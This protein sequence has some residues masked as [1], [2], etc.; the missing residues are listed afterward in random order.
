MTVA[1]EEGAP[2]LAS[3]NV[4]PL[5]RPVA[6]RP[7]PKVVGELDGIARQLGQVESRKTVKI[8][9]IRGRRYDMAIAGDESPLRQ[10]IVFLLRGRTEYQLLCRWRASDSEPPACDL[11]EQSFTPV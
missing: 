9:G 7:W 11:L 3:V 1:P 4:Y 6:S 5:L 2:E 10:R 8:A